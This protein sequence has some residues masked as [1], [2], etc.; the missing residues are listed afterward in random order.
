MPLA[1]SYGENGMRGLNDRV[2]LAA[3]VNA[4]QEEHARLAALESK[5]GLSHVERPTLA[6]S[7]V[8]KEV[9]QTKEVEKAAREQLR[10]RQRQQ[11]GKTCKAA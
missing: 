8:A 10:C 5:A 9:A 7:V 11:E 2:I 3:V 6:P 4:I 1:V